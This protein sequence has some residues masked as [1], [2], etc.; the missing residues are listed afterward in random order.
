MKKK[1]AS[2]LAMAVLIVNS[3]TVSNV[4]A[5]ETIKE[6]H[7]SWYE[8]VLKFIDIWKVDKSGLNKIVKDGKKLYEGEYTEKSFSNFEDNL[9][10]ANEVLN[11]E[12]TTQEEIDVVT[13]E[14]NESMKALDKLNLDEIVNIPDK[15]LAN[16]L[17]K[18][19]HKEN[20]FTV[21]DMQG[22]VKLKLNPE[23]KSLEGLQ[24]ARHLEC[25]TD[26]PN[27]VS[28]LKL[29]DK[30]TSLKEVNFK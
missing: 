3:V 5:N 1:L 11:K 17:G 12:R 23:V 29:L 6:E 4:F 24:Y 18:L 13:K 27:D 10:K 16:S 7:K 14:L 9:I 26:I 20:N 19:L 15:Y 8:K 28:N 2:V 30:L 22:L 25:I 21:R